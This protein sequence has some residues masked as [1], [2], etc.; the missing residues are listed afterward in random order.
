MQ[1]SLLELFNGNTKQTIEKI[2]GAKMK[3]PKAVYSVIKLR[4][5]LE[6]EN[7]NV[8]EMVKQILE[9]WEKYP[10]LKEKA[11]EIEVKML[12]DPLFDGQRD[13]RNIQNEIGTYV[14]DK[15]DVFLKETKV[16][17]VISPI[18]INVLLELGLTNSEVAS[19]EWLTDFGE[20]M[21][22]N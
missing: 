1:V 18:D 2:Y 14:N 9:E 10:E 16:D 13:L 15:I 4:R 3:D 8:D 19:V 7:K 17:L 11:G 5:K 20:T 6:Q 12:N 22:E 21:E